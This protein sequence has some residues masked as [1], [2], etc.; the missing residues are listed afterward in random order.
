MKIKE[1]RNRIGWSQAIMSAYMGIPESTIKK[2]ES[3]TATPPPYVERLIV[4]EIE[5]RL[6]AK[7]A[8]SIK[9]ETVDRYADICKKFSHDTA[10][11]SSLSSFS[12]FTTDG[13]FSWK[14][15]SDNAHNGIDV[16][17]AFGLSDSEIEYIAAEQLFN[18][19][20]EEIELAVSDKW[21]SEQIALTLFK[22]RL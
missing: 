4:A 17:W 5:R 10:D 9:N 2:W 15:T 20:Y 18:L 14:E 12:F 22:F 11:L 6:S 8:F 1:A 21:D 7:P 19:L 3:G 13:S 16:S